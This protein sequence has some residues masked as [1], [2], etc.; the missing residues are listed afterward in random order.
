MGCVTGGIPRRWK[1]LSG[2]SPV[3]PDFPPD[4][5]ES[6]GLPGCTG[7]G[8]RWWSG[9]H[10]RPVIM[11][12]TF[13]RLDQ[14]QSSIFPGPILCEPLGTRE[15]PGRSTGVLPTRT[16]CPVGCTKRTSFGLYSR[17]LSRGYRRSPSKGLRRRGV[18]FRGPPDCVSRVCPYPPMPAR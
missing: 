4:S 17:G 10:V 5:Q 6:G 13:P 7:L 18:P 8:R 1:I 11:L 16:S 2:P 14:T 9:V 12:P 15:K 3:R